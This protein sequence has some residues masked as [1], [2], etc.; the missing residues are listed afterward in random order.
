MQ[1]LTAPSLQLATGKVPFPEYTTLNVS[2]VT[3]KG[4]RPLKPARFEAPG[5]TP[6][7]WKIA[8]KCWHQKAEKRP[9]AHVVLRDLETLLQVNVCTRCTCTCLPWEVVDLESE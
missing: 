4:K 9:E 8:K 6:E 2:L 7:V 5:I 3:S 1:A